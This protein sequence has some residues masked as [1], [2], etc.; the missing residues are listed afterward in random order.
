MASLIFCD[1]WQKAQNHLV[2]VSQASKLPCTLP[3][4]WFTFCPQEEFEIFQHEIKIPKSS[5]FLSSYS[6]LSLPTH[7]TVTLSSTYIGP[8]KSVFFSF[9]IVCIYLF[10]LHDNFSVSF[11]CQLIQHLHRR[12]S[13]TATKM[14]QNSLPCVPVVPCSLHFILPIN[15]HENFQN[16]FVKKWAFII[17]ILSSQCLPQLLST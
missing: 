6:G 17:S 14:G 3:W 13:Y 16:A 7:S 9:L 11:R 10:P 8:L 15:V 12:T 4:H 5:G 2:T 1:L